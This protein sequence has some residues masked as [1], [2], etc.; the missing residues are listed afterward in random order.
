MQWPCA[1]CGPG[2]EGQHRRVPAGAVCLRGPGSVQPTGMGPAK[3][4]CGAEVTRW[5]GLG[6]SVQKVLDE[7]Q[8]LLLPYPLHASLAEFFSL[9]SS[10]WCLGRWT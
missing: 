10:F 4:C 5:P 8:T 6:R 7:A 1:A 3:C 9:H 2:P